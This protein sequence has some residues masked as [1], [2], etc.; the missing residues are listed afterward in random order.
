[1]LVYGLFPRP[2]LMHSVSVLE[3]WNTGYT[4]RILTTVM[5]LYR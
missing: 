2:L 5:I 4:K 1:M 3:H